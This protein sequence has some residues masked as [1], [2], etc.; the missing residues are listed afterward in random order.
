MRAKF[1]ISVL[2]GYVCLQGNTAT[3]H[4]SQSPFF[5]LERDI[6]ISGVVQ[7][8]DFRNPHAILYV[9]VTDEAGVTAVW[10]LQFA[11]LAILIRSGITANSFQPGDQ[12]IAVG[13]PSRNPESNGMAGIQAT[14]EDGTV[15]ID[16]LRSGEFQAQ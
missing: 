11:S 16:P 9:E 3:A 8:F 5:D 15:L 1:I 12:I 14:K 7:R 2:L 4:H 10:S 13:H 6:E